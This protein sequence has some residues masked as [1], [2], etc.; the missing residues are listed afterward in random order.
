MSLS[1]NMKDA[2]HAEGRW[3][4]QGEYLQRNPTKKKYLVSM[5]F[6]ELAEDSTLPYLVQHGFCDKQ[7]GTCTAY[8]YTY[9][10]HD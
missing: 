6:R 7:H 5:S 9:S 10:K 1:G 8:T 2:S 3:K 4:A